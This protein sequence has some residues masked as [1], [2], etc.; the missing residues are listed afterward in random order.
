MILNEFLSRQKHDNSNPYEIIAISFNM[1]NILHKRYYNIGKSARY[2][3]QMWSQTNSSQIKLP[4]VHGVSKN[5]HPNI[6][7]EKQI[8]KSMK[9]N[10]ISQEKSRIR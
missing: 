6:H 4:E 1:H 8:T 10:E 9:G 7:P 5:L 3:G 2:L